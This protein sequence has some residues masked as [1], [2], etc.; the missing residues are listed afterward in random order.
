MGEYLSSPEHFESIFA[1]RFAPFVTAIVNG[2]YWEPKY[3]RLL[4]V[5]DT[6]TLL[7]SPSTRLLSIADITCDLHVRAGFPLPIRAY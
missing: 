7:A 5:A 3:P 4:S 2:I 6:D 1:T